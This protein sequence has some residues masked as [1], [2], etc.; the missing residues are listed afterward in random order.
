[1]KT[2]VFNITGSGPLL[3]S[4]FFLTFFM[5]FVLVA[6]TYI[7][8]V[9]AIAVKVIWSFLISSTSTLT[10]IMTSPPTIMTT[11]MIVIMIMMITIV[12]MM[13]M[14]MMMMMKARKETKKKELYLVILKDF[15]I[16]SPKS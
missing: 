8:E 9:K 1:M 16:Q 14:M 11:K 15:Q 10:T 6:L 7:Q 12:T 2:R 4:F 3:K 5:L 13:M